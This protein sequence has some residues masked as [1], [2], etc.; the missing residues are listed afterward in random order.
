MSTYIKNIVVLFLL[1]FL[2]FIISSSSQMAHF[3]RVLGILHKINNFIALVF[4]TL[5]R[6]HCTSENLCIMPTITLA[7]KNTV[8]NDDLLTASCLFLRYCPVG[9][10]F[11]LAGQIVKMTDIEKIGH[12]VAMYAATVITGLAIHSFF[13]LPLIYFIVTHKNPFRFMS[14]VLQALTTAFG[15]SSRSARHLT[16]NKWTMMEHHYL[17]CTLWVFSQFCNLTCNPPLYGGKSQLEQTNNT[18]HASYWGH[19]E[20][21]WCSAL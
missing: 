9:I 10:L 14:G 2:S 11:L 20:H 3:D 4:V 1:V 15:T 17:T 7:M 21:G 16:L 18:L 6:Y 13:T 12:A 19:S 5:P 8:K